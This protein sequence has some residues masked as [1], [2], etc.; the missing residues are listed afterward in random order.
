MEKVQDI[1]GKLW[2]LCN[3][4]REAGITYPEYVTELT[5]LI[6]LKMAEETGSEKDL[7]P[8]CR[9]GDLTN[10]NGIEQFQFYKEMLS[11]LGSSARGRVKEIFS[12]AETCLSHARHLALLVGEFDTI[13]WYEAREETALAQL[14]EGLLEKNSTESKS[15]AGQYFTPRPVIDSVVK[16]MKPQLGEVVQ[17]PACG[18]AGFLIA[19]DRYIKFHSN[20]FAGLTRRELTF[21]RERAF[22]GVELVSKT[23][24][25]ALMN[26]ILHGIFGPVI[27]GDALG[28]AGDSL[29][30]ADIILTNPPFGTKR[31]AGL[32]SRAFP[33]ATSNKQL[34]FLQHVYLG[35]KPGGR[36]AVVMP[37]LQGATA[38]RVCAD[39][40]EKCRLHTV[41]RLPLGIFYALGVKTNVL[42]FTRGQSD[43]NNT[44]KTWIYDLRT[45]M[46]RFGKR[47]PL[48]DKYFEP[49]ERAYGGKAD[50]SSKRVPDERFRCFSRE[51]IRLNDES[52]DI[53]WL[54]EA[55][56]IKTNQQKSPDVLINEVVARLRD[57]LKEFDSLSR[58]TKKKN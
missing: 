53:V 11:R 46:P 20:N 44:R 40:M 48:T 14:Y 41:L 38:R 57:I 3:I 33:T 28:D 32:P 52:T 58:E 7:P 4:L 6:F 37:D 30:R 13:N 55:G 23:H 10:S 27:L 8:G 49:F 21:Q 25:L 50:G 16:V 26:T 43:H 29:A 17:D 54:R 51:D 1:I 24:K 35:L 15:G 2:Y 31:G 9:W 47:T 36:A 22:I 56:S 18:T 5:Y 45:N 34:A 12:D 39:L 19:A 42:F